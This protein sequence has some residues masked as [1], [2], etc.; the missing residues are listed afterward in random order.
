MPPFSTVAGM[1]AKAS[2]INMEGLRRNHFSPEQIDAI[3]KSFHHL[4]RENLLLSEA[5]EKINLLAE[6][7]DA[8]KKIADFICDTGKRGLIR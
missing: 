8:A 3:K 4:Y 6:Q 7:S 5:R 1:P 2:G